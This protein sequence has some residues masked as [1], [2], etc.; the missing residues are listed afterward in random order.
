MFGL[1]SWVVLTPASIHPFIHSSIHPF[2]HSSIHPFIHAVERVGAVVLQ[3]EV[4]IEG[5]DE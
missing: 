3:V 5:N 4:L 2:I 1:A